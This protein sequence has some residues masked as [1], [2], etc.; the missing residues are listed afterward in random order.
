MMAYHK[1]KLLTLL[2]V[3]AVIVAANRMFEQS[4]FSDGLDKVG[5]LYWLG[6]VLLIYI[7]YYVL[8]LRCPN[9]KCRRPQIYRS[10]SPKDWRLPED[11]CYHCG[12]KL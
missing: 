9:P 3:E 7:V 12:T 6:M 11:K 8:T 1:T 2:F 4:N 5:W 10:Q